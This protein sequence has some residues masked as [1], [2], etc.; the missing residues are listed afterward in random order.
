[1]KFS[2]F[3]LPRWPLNGLGS[4]S[5]W[6][7]SGDCRREESWKVVSFGGQL[8]NVFIVNK[9]SVLKRFDVIDSSNLLLVQ[10]NL[11][12]SFFYL[13][14]VLQPSQRTEFHNKTFYP[15]DPT[16]QHFSVS[17]IEGIVAG[18]SLVHVPELS[19]H[20]TS[21]DVALKILMM[22]LSYYPKK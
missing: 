22:D 16:Y 21:E 9:R 2:C 10:H 7:C 17:L 12:Q 1:M 4:S 5:G 15:W 18:G 6:S 20:T 3:L 14:Q 8:T 19:S 11:S 13:S